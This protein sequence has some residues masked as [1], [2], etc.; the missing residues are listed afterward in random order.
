MIC[1]CQTTTNFYFNQHVAIFTTLG[2]GPIA[3]T[4]SSA[5]AAYS[6]QC[7]PLC[8]GYAYWQLYYMGPQ[9]CECTNNPTAYA[10]GAVNADPFAYGYV[11]GSGELALLPGHR[12]RATLSTL[13]IPPITSHKHIS[14]LLGALTSIQ[15]RHTAAIAAVQQAS[16]PP[17]PVPS[18]S[19]SGGGVHD[20]PIIKVCGMPSA[21]FPPA[22][23]WCAASSLVHRRRP[24][25]KAHGPLAHDMHVMPMAWQQ[26]QGQLLFIL[27]GKASI[28]LP[29]PPTHPPCECRHSTV[30]SE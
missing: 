24:P 15:C 1:S 13:L 25:A 30:P 2:N 9:Y 26:Q 21:F 14:T 18:P 19:P 3:S 11:G 16:P 27:S 7:C 4:N 29:A 8:A 17:S 5:I 10:N 23:D 28:E 12:G 6:A 22:S 20:D